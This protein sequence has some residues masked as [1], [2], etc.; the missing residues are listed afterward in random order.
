[1]CDFNLGSLNLNGAR[2]DFKRAALFKLMDIKKI[3]IMFVQETHS[4]TDNES[5][6]RQ[7]FNGEVV[8]SHKSSCS[9][10]VGVFCQFLLTLKK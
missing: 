7:A 5:E 2:A 1:M 3:N 9:G 10:G 6:W 8:L 4:T